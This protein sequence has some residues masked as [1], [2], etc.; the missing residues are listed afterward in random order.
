MLAGLYCLVLLP[1]THKY[2]STDTLLMANTQLAE[3]GC[4]VHRTVGDLP[5]LPFVP[6]CRHHRS[7]TLASP[8][9]YMH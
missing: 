4:R 9:S 1:C 2:V 5:T 7:L 8:T 6:L 3:S